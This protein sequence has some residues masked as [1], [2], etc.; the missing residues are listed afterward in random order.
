M[1]KLILLIFYSLLTLWASFYGGHLLNINSYYGGEH[2]YDIPY[3]ITCFL[4]IILSV[5][6][7]MF[8]A[9]KYLERH[10]D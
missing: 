7:T 3:E 10:D 9:I 1:I 8:S 4:I 6:Y 2:W 5:I